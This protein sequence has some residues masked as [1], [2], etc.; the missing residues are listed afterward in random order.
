MICYAN[1][2]NKTMRN[3]HLRSQSRVCTGLT[4]ATEVWCKDPD[5]RNQTEFYQYRV[6][7]EVDPTKIIA[8]VL[9]SAGGEGQPQFHYFNVFTPYAVREDPHKKVFLVVGPLKRGW[10]NTS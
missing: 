1:F 7:I 5:S 4:P 9:N 10:G 6:F 8:F 3:L 2:Q